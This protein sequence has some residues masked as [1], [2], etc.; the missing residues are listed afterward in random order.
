MDLFGQGNLIYNDIVGEYGSDADTTIVKELMVSRGQT[1][2][3]TPWA[4]SSAEAGLGNTPRITVSP[5]IAP[6]P[7]H[8]HNAVMNE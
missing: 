3:F 4:P 8:R 7:E 6:L 1:I 5:P 2:W